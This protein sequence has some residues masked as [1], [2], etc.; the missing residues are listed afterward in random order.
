MSWKINKLLL[1]PVF[2]ALSLIIVLG[3]SGIEAGE[4]DIT[5]KRG[6]AESDTATQPNRA[7]PKPSRRPDAKINSSEQET[8]LLLPA[9]QK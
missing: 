6:I 7:V 3:A 5:L 8:G 4:A 1:N 9:I 2:L